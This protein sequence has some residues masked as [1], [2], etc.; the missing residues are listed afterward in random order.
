[1]SIYIYHTITALLFFSSLVRLFAELTIYVI[2]VT[3]P[4]PFNLGSVAGIVCAAFTIAVQVVFLLLA[5]KMLKNKEEDEDVE[6][7]E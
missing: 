6:M 3:E 2:L 4:I 7:R 5:T 1:M